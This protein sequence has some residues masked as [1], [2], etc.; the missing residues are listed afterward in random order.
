ML[1]AEDRS[2]RDLEYQRLSAT[3]IEGLE[4]SSVRSSGIAHCL[5]S[6]GVGWSRETNLTEGWTLNGRL[7]GTLDFSPRAPKDW[8]AY[9][10]AG[11]QDSWAVAPRL[12]FQPNHQL[13]QP[14]S[15]TTEGSVHNSML[16]R[17]PLWN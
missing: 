12:G 17:L 1:T 3:V 8:H 14:E 9:L 6:M 7:F 10:S 13:V 4:G 15:Y 5:K 16:C 2:I 11:P